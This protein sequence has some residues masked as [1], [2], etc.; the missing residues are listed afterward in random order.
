M[1][2]RNSVGRRIS[3][4]NES[5]APVRAAAPSKSYS[6]SSTATLASQASTTLSSQ[7]SF[8]HNHHNSA[9]HRLPPLP[10]LHSR[11]SS[12]ASTPLSSP[13]TPPLSRSDSSDSRIMQIP[14]PVTPDFAFDP[15]LAPAPQQ[16]FSS[17]QFGGGKQAPSAASVAFFPPMPKD[18]G[19]AQQQIVMPYPAMLQQPQ[20]PYA[21]PAPPQQQQQ[22]DANVLQQQ[23]AAA[24][25][26]VTNAETSPN[27][28]QQ[29]TPTQPPTKSGGG[30]TGKPQSKKNQYPCPMAKQFNCHDYF[31][32]SGHAAR[33]A[34]KH[35]GRK[36]AL[37][38]E[39]NKAFTRKD[40]MEQHRR[41]HQ[42]GRGSNSK[43]GADGSGSADSN[44]AAAPSSSRKSSKAAQGGNGGSSSKRPKPSPLQ[45][46]QQRQAEA[47]AAAAAA[48]AAVQIPAIDPM[49]PASPVSSS[50]VAAFPDAA[51]LVPPAVGGAGGG[52]PVAIQP[53]HSFASQ[54]IDPIPYRY[55]AL[56]SFT[57]GLDTLAIV[58]TGE[59]RKRKYDE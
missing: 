8:Y 42:N 29:Q 1:D 38:P 10:R 32:T 39:C 20:Q 49:L 51:P 33:H 50:L 23:Q 30:S 15:I 35:T 26:P 18:G 11:A 16:Q 34:K 58:A 9:S 37:C 44:A 47:A 25:L 19:V 3:L 59:D 36:D 57:T 12:Y 13:Q 55:D 21:Y 41:T 22:A 31:T 56:P 4:L 28:D 17:P 45:A 54:Y 43:G 24:Y 2:G 7:H 46:D 48:A 27:A 5:E 53:L 52:G 40:N 6:S 14:S